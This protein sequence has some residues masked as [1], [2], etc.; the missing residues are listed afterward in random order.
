MPAPFLFNRR[1]NN[2]GYR[3]N[4]PRP[5]FSFKARSLF[6]FFFFPLHQ[7]LL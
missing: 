6:Q 7:R 4:L 1:R 2:R 3:N 5:F